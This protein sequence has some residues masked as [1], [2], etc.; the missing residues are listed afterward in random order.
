MKRTLSIDEPNPLF[1]FSYEVKL[2]FTGEIIAESE[3]QASEL[4]KESMD[5]EFGIYTEDDEITI[6]ESKY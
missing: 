4:I 1:N 5:Y 2:V 6:K 3:E